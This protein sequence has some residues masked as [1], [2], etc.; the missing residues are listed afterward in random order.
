VSATFPLRCQQQRQ[1]L[2]LCLC[3]AAAGA[4]RWSYRGVGPELTQR[5]WP[6]V[7]NLTRQPMEGRSREGGL[8]FGEMERDCVISHG[9]AAFLKVCA[10]VDLFV[11]CLLLFSI[12][13]L[14]TG[15]DTWPWAT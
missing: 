12:V 7:T 4:E 8:R 3:T 10:R 9:A 1:H 14:G 15:L 13:S 6:Q 11:I 2:Q 5:A